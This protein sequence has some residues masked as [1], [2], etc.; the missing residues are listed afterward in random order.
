MS[1]SKVGY[2]G[3]L[4]QLE[5]EVCFKKEKGSTAHLKRTAGAIAERAEGMNER[6]SEGARV[7]LQR[8][9]K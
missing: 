7:V 1:S 9:E 4:C 3:E 8:D 6:R 2:G 5:V